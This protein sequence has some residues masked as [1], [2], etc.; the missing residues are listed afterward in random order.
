MARNISRHTNSR[1]T[2]NHHSVSHSVS[3]KTMWQLS[4]PMFFANLSVPLIPLSDTFVLGHLPE[5]LYLAAVAIAS[6]VF[7]FATLLFTF[8]TLSTTSLVSTDLGQNK[9]QSAKAWALRSIVLAACAGLA[10]TLIIP[11]VLLPWLQLLGIT[12]NLIPVALNYGHVMLYGLFPA[13]VTFSFQGILLGHHKSRS[14]M[15]IALVTSICNIACNIVFAWVWDYRAVGVAWAS[16]L[17]QWLGLFIAVGLVKPLLWHGLFDNK[18]KHIFHSSP[19]WQLVHL[20]KDL[21]IQAL[22][23]L[24]YFQLIIKMSSELGQTVVA[25]NSII[26][27]YFITSFR[28]QEAITLS[29][30]MLISRIWQVD[31]ILAIRQAYSIFFQWIASSMFVVAS[32]VFICGEQIT[33]LMTSLSQV[34]ELVVQKIALVVFYVVLVSWTYF[35][36]A[37]LLGIS[38]TQRLRNVYIASILVLIMLVNQF[39]YAAPSDFRLWFCVVS[40]EITRLILVIWNYHRAF[41]ELKQHSAQ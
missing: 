26:I 12:H 17:S 30:Q 24:L 28:L 38:A 23:I 29:V 7:S 27:L 9:S 8:I 32:V 5:S 16:V 1:H 41:F 39:Y 20:N 40:F 35:Y 22:C 3:H 15:C 10:M 37:L 14:I 21:L 18:L 2:I 31:Q 4:W 19:L 6:Q 34:Q 33:Q 36:N 13:I 11:W 25:A